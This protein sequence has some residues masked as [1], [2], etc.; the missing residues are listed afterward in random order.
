MKLKIL[1]KRM[2]CNSVASKP[3]GYLKSKLVFIMNLTAIILTVC[4]LSLSAAGYSQKITLSEDN[5]PLKSVLQKI[6][7]QSGYQLVYNSDVIGKASPVSVNIKNASLTE[8]LTLSLA[9][10]PLSFRISDNIILIKP[11]IQRAQVKATPPVNIKGTVTDAKGETL[12]GVSVVVKGTTTGTTTDMNGNYSLTAPDEN[13][14]LVFTYLGFESQEVTVNNREALNIVLRESASA[15]SEVVVTALGIS[16]EAKSLTY[17]TQKVTSD[18]LTKATGTNVV[19]G[20]QGKIAGLTITR[21][22]NGVGGASTV[23]LRGNR[24]I[25]GNN[26]PLYVT[27]GVPGGIGLEDGDNIESITVLK[28][29]AAAALYGSAGQNGVIL[30][31]TKKGKAGR[32]SVEFNGGLLFD[33]ANI[34]HELQDQYGQGDAGLYVNSS[35]HSFGPK[36][37]GQPVT[38][39]N[40]TTTNLAAQ[41]DQFENFFRTGT[42]LNNSLN[43]NMGTEK[44]QTYFSYGNIRAE[45]IMQNNT[46]NRHNVN[47]RVSSNLTK[48]LSIDTK[49]TYNYEKVENSPSS[50]AITS[51]YRT[52]VTIP[53]SEMEKYEYVDASGNPRQSYWKPG[54][55]IIG[56]PYFYMNKNLNYDDIHRAVGLLAV[57]YDFNNWLSLQVRGNVN[58]SFSSSDTRIYSDSYHSLV[59]SNYTQGNGRDLNSNID[60][61]LTFKRDLNKNFNLSGHI[62]GYMQGSRNTGTTANA[63]GLYKADFFYLSNARSPQITN[64]FAQSPLI[65]SL[66]SAA[67]VAYKNYLYLDVT[68]RNDWSSALPTG[69]QSVFYPSIGL[70]AVV[71]DMVK[72]PSWIS[73]G[74]AR[75]SSANAGN[76]G[77]AYFGREYYTLGIGGIISTPTIQS[78]DNYKPEL[79]K[80]F[81]AGLDW[82]F[83]NNRL[84]LDL[85]YYKTRTENQLLLIGAP[86][87]STYNQR[88]INAGLIEND[89]IELV[90]SAT[91]LKMGKFAWDAT[92]NY[93]K[94][95]NN[96]VSITPEM[97]S[98]IIQ[99]DDIVTTKV[100]EGRSFGEL[101]SKGWQRDAQGRKLVDNMGRPLLT[102]GKT[103]YMGNYNPDFMV[104]FNNSFSYSKLA[105]TF[106]IDY[107]KG[108][109]ILGGTQPLLDA[110]GHSLRSLEGRENGIV[111]DAY[112][113]DGTK[114]T[115]SITSQ[116]YFSAIGD[117]KPTGE[118]YNYSSTNVRLREVTLDYTLPASLF[119]KS[120]Y[121]K[122]AKISLIG[123]NLFFFQRSAPFDPEISR[124]RGGT[125]Y[126]ALPFTRSFGLNLR[127]SF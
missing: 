103:V 43:V 105:L 44:M 115:K 65:Q 112:L 95:N 68:G 29:A 35:E 14:V 37:T 122:N 98:V 94:N 24:S 75:V 47:L 84:G 25:T 34:Y 88:Y 125:E 100:E 116:A 74:K 57:K 101:Y 81:E 77:N 42:T 27:D 117:R 97:K 55:S 109:S 96:V 45:G 18:E 54:S 86:S 13:A 17:S 31:T 76:G 12:I 107:R 23:L 20:L 118:E 9:G 99:D 127:A 10:Q 70:T 110:D 106:Q 102:P 8:A 28:G 89:G 53:T 49:I 69:E 126:T 66:Y 64:N 120:N 78:F 50:F 123:R 6:R 71:S 93:S 61:L 87:A 46:L 92:L 111:L 5:A 2:V 52:P 1:S 108:G 83:F 33:Q 48:K 124:G 15:L 51:I 21:S 114:N 85:T 16:R 32:T 91:P 104:G 62:G 73:Y 60:G 22:T 58:Q 121:I 90:M 7:K 26:A 11:E 4:S 80:S 72:L 113:A 63:N 82:R 119:G 3:T 38:L 79:T 19:N 67:T 39:W 59:G 41:P 30:I 40:G 56:N 36:I